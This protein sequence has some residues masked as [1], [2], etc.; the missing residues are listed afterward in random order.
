MLR[1]MNHNQW[2]W[3]VPVHFNKFVGY[4]LV[5]SSTQ[6]FC[7]VFAVAAFHSSMAKATTKML[8]ES[9]YNTMQLLDIRFLWPLHTLF[10][11]GQLGSFV[12]LCSDYNDQN[13]IEN[14]EH[15]ILCQSQ[16]I[17][18]LLLMNVHYTCVSVMTFVCVAGLSSQD[19]FL[20]L[21]TFS[22]PMVISQLKNLHIIVCVHVTHVILVIFSHHQEIKC[23]FSWNFINNRIQESCIVLNYSNFNYYWR[24]NF[25]SDV[26]V[27]V[28]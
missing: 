28:C 5:C 17:F 21:N 11:T 18:G 19:Y 3:F 13:D 27:P 16:I 20:L 26:R 2:L 4:V 15:L 6:N 7:Y 25:F 14:I 10:G 9:V 22:F 23:F 24:E 8:A 12:S 1:I